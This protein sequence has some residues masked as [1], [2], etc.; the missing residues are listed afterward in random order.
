[1]KTF[2]LVIDEVITPCTNYI[3]STD[4]YNRHQAMSLEHIQKV[5]DDICGKVYDTEFI[6]CI[7][8][9]CEQQT[10]YQNVNALHTII[11]KLNLEKKC[12]NITFG[13]K[14]K[15]LVWKEIK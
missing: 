7:I 14:S 1:M 4:I 5:I 12:F 13:K 10:I 2:E 8:E 6:K 11:Y 15:Q 9:Q 3:I